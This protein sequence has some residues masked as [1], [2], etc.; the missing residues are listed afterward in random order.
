MPRLLTLFLLLSLVL[1]AATACASG[2]TED[3]TA[4]SAP[5]TETPA[6]MPTSTPAATPEVTPETTPDPLPAAADLAPGTFR[7][8]VS[9]AAEGAVEGASEGA[10]YLPFGGGDDTSVRLVIDAESADGEPLTVF[11]RLVL[12]AGIPA[13][14]H[15]IGATL[16]GADDIDVRGFATVGETDFRELPEGTLLL[17]DIDADGITG[18]FAFVVRSEDGATLQVAGAFRALPLTQG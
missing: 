6:P 16:R 18:R 10:D 3:P 14:S 4:T 2:D 11:V 17:E 12:R 9:G 13:G 5:P 8:S 15:V 7:L 1:V